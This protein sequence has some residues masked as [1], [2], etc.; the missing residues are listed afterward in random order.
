MKLK[1]VI[2][3]LFLSCFC[4]AQEKEVAQATQQFNDFAYFDAIKIYERV[5]ASGYKSKELFQKLGNAYYFS[6]DYENAAKAYKELF[7]LTDDQHPEYF[8]RYAQALK[9]IEDYDLSK[10]YMDKFAAFNIGDKRAN[11]YLKKNDYLKA[12]K[13]NSGRYNI[14]ISEFNSPYSDYGGA[15]LGNKLV[16]TTTRDTGGAFKSKMKWTNAAFSNFYQVSFDNDGSANKAERF[17]SKVNSVLNESSAVFTA[18]G[19]TMYFTRNNYLNGKR[20]KNNR[21]QVLLKIYKAT[22]D[23]GKWGDVEELPFNSDE[24]STAHPAL[25]L[26]E[27]YLYFASD[28]PGG[29]GKS[30]LYVVE[31]KKDGTFGEVQTLGPEIN[32][33]S[34]ET[35]PFVTGDNTLYFASDGHPGLGG[36]DVFA[37]KLKS[38]TTTEEIQN[39]GEPVNSPFDD[40]AFIIDDKNKNG[41]F[42]SNRPSEF[43]DDDI[44]QLTEI[45]PLECKQKVV[46]VVV[47]EKTQQPLPNAQVI[48]LDKNLQRIDEMY[49]NDKGGFSFELNCKSVYT[50]RANKQSYETNEVLVKTPDFS[51]DVSAKIALSQKT[52]RFQ[53]GEDI[54]PK[55]GIKMIY[56]DLDKS[57]IRPDAAI[58]LEKIRQVLIEYPNMKID[59]RSHTD[60]RA[61]A[62]YNEKLSDRRA[63]STRQWLIDNGIDA[64]RLSARGYGESQPINKCVDGVKC[65]EEEHQANRRSQF[66][67]L[68]L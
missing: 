68:S 42:T 26:D 3:F 37:T 52:P 40:F 53:K 60:C 33:E 19:K 31:I 55:V 14:K 49:A 1:V 65:S 27:K 64:S 21:E 34:R 62:A 10:V 29:V 58:E 32:T 7:A 57:F 48:L 51:G 46:G 59:I 63:Q 44:Y 41:F 38:P 20:H 16:F 12:I 9:S 28:R 11:V 23:D 50:L 35:F 30:D 4:L 25:S 61:T 8:Y 54:A 2:S 18:D 15:F 66:I 13:Q 45:K 43:G 17:N 36:T 24:F 47:D 22:L 56:F 6:A 67:I 39:V 5:A